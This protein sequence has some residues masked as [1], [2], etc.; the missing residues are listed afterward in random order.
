[1]Q[2]ARDAH[3]VLGEMGRVLGELEA[4]VAGRAP[5]ASPPSPPE[6]LAGVAAGPFS[7]LDAVEGFGARLRDLEGVL[8]VVHRGFE[9]ERAL[10]DVRLGAPR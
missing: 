9:G 1:V 8:D 5:P 4:L 3:A 7:A 10:F 2:A 6:A